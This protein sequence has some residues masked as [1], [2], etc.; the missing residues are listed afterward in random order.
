MQRA[1]VA[2]Q[3]PVPLDARGLPRVQRRVLTGHEAEVAEGAGTGQ[4]RLD[5]GLGVEEVHAVTAVGPAFRQALAADGA[6]E[7]GFLLQAFQLTDEAQA[8]FEQ[9]DP[10]LLAVE[11]VL[12]R[13][14]QARPEA[15]THR[16]H[17]GGD[18]VGQGQRLGARI[19]QF[20]Q[21]R[22]DE[23]EGDRFLVAAG[24]QQAP[25][26][27]QRGARFRLVVRRQARLRV[28]HRQAIVSV[29]TGQ[30]LDQVDFQGNVEAMARYADRPLPFPVGYH[31]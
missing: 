9:A 2:D 26:Q 23:A 4:H 31:R 3:P 11:V 22:I 18:R 5:I 16:R 30:F 13:L 27:R 29:E 24:D 7:H 25:Q 17:V 20:E 1:Q 15:G 19:E 28:A 10:R 14:D 8:A 6:G 21:G 12:Q